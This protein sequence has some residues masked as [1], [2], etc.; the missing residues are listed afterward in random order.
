MPDYPFE[1]LDVTQ[2]VPPQ[3]T[4]FAHVKKDGHPDLSQK[5]QPWKKWM[6]LS[7]TDSD[8]AEEVK[9]PHVVILDEKCAFLGPNLGGY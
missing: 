3:N 1:V 5:A 6:N 7:G 8:G 4:S 9:L 2:F